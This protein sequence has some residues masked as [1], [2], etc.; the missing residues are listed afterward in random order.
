MSGMHNYKPSPAEAIF[1]GQL[2]NI[3]TK[4]AGIA[5]DMLAKG[6]SLASV[7]DCFKSASNVATALR[8]QS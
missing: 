2:L 3:D 1:L 6:A 5:R 7:V 8:G 4:L